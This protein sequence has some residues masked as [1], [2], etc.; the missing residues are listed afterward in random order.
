VL[1]SGRYIHG[2]EVEAFEREFASYCGALGAVGVGNGLE[3]LHLTLV[4]LGIG[5][6][7]EVIVPAHT[8]IATWLAVTHTGARPVPVEPDPATMQIDAARVSDS[9]TTRTA[10]ILP[11]HLY[12][13]PADLEALAAI[14]DQH[15]LVLV[16]DASQ[17]HG[18][19]FGG[20]SVGSLGDAVA[21]SL[22][23]TKNLGAI[24]DAGIV[25]SSDQDLLGRVRMLGNYGE[26][27]RNEHELRGHNSR[28]DE[29]QAAMLRVK[30][31]HLDM[32]NGL[33]R[34]RADQYLGALSASAGVELPGVTPSAHPVWHQFVIRVRSR[35]AVREELARRGVGT[36]VHYPTPPHR[37]AAY[38]VD[39]PDALPITEQLA[40]SVLSLPISPA[41][42][43]DDCAY[44][45]RA[46]TE[47]VAAHRA[48]LR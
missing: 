43:E 12:G 5:A 28:L 22:Y 26:R 25:V 8:Y 6:G 38:T 46:L 39:Y 31:G 15:G 4:A 13:M 19:L 23:P 36:L 44:V 16:A 48:T 40:K 11:T 34:A 45:A 2:P 37:A 18:A 3:A 47:S 32:W 33:R 9:I 42:S 14:A 10:A 35:D 17:A 24:G 41:L 1:R 21:F 27:G 29:L 30:L 20:R 7:D